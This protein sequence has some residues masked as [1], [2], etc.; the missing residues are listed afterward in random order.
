M[1]IKAEDQ[2]KSLEDRL[3][4]AGYIHVFGADG[5]VWFNPGVNP[6]KWI[7]DN[8]DLLEELLE[9]AASR[10]AAKLAATEFADSASSTG[11]QSTGEQSKGEQS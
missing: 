2:R 8:R 10:A 3:R 6:F 1:R 9:R 11:E 4:L 7:V 5:D